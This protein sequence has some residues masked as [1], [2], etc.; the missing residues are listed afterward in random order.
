MRALNKF[1][2]E[3][4]ASYMA[5]MKASIGEAIGLNGYSDEDDLLQR[6][7]DALNRKRL[8]LIAVSQKKAWLSNNITRDTLDKYAYNA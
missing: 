2:A 3:D 4:R 6:K 7:V 5:L 8:E 1:N